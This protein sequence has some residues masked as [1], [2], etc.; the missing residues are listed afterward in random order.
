MET[1]FTV[2]ALLVVVAIVASVL[3]V[4]VVAPL[5]V[6]QHS[7]PRRSRTQYSPRL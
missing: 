1:F 4:F 7:Q 5:W 6:P 2:L 3:W